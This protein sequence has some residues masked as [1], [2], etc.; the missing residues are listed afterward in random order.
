[1][2]APELEQL[3]RSLPQRVTEPDAWP[4]FDIRVTLFDGKA[5]L[6]MGFDLIALDAASIHAL[7]REWGLMYDDP[8]TVLPL[9]PLSFRDVV[10]EQI[11][12]RESEAWKRS[13]RYWKG[14]ALSL[15]PGPDLPLAP[16]ASERTGQRFR[17]RGTIVSAEGAQALRRQ[18][19]ARGLTLP[20]LLAAVYADVLARWSRNQHFCITV[21]SFN[22]PDLHPAM[23]QVLGDYTSTILLEV[24][25][26]ADRFADRATKLARQ[27]ADDVEHSEYS[28][29]QV[30]RE[31]ARQT[32]SAVAYAGVVFTSALGFRRASAGPKSE[33]G[34][35]DRLGTTVYNVSST[36]QVADR[37]SRL[38]GGR[39]SWSASWDVVEALFPPGVVDAMV[40][41]LRRAAAGA[42]D[43]HGLGRGRG[44][45]RRPCRAR[46]MPRPRPSC[47]TPP[48]SAGAAQRPSAWR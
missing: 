38:R 41:G 9:V 15:P 28:G 39:R 14:R 46:S 37:P 6:H 13:E 17:R 33:S 10:M 5:R 31:I 22:R 43:R 30:M 19:Q 42:G 47:C 16:D 3:R 34:G 8:A 29:I 18:A 27:L 20:T 12:Y 45:R 24:D 2:P 40:A 21:T 32:A 7:R 11:A 36:P 44:R 25:A 23:A 26:R 35:W 4:L 1:M 48:S